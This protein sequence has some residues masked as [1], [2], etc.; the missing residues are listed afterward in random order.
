M[1]RPIQ[2]PLAGRKCLKAV[3]VMVRKQGFLVSPRQSTPAGA[4]G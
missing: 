4:G 1:P 3:V 2:R